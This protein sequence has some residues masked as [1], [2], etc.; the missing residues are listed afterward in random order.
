MQSTNQK[1]AGIGIFIV[2]FK[3]RKITLH[4][5]KG[6]NFPRKYNNSKCKYN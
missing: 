2:D 4:N 6:V 1:K 5:E 3:T